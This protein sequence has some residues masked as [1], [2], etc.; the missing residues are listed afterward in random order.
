VKKLLLITTALV[1][2]LASGLVLFNSSNQHFPTVL[3]PFAFDPII[4]VLA[5]S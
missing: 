2:S 3:S 5:A 1:I 4:S